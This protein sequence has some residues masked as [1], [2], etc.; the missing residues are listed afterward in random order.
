MKY[1]VMV[2]SLMSMIFVVDTVKA[3]EMMRVRLVNHLGDTEQLNVSF[4]GE[5]F[6]LDPTVHL[7]EGVTYTLTKKNEKLIVEGG[8]ETYVT[9]EPFL[10]IPSTYDYQHSVSINERPYLGAMEIRIEDNKFIR[11]VNQLP[12][13]D[14]LKGVVPFEVF[15][16]WSLETLKAQSLAARTY[17]AMHSGKEIDDTISY[18]VYGGYMWDKNTTKAV[19]ETEGEVITYKDKLISAFYSAS[20]GGMTENNS[21]VWGGEALPF[22]PIKEDPYDPTHPW[23]FSIH[24]TQIDLDDI[25]GTDPKWWDDLEEKDSEITTNIKSWLNRN[26]YPGDIKILSIPSF[27]ISGE[28]LAS[29]RSVIG[30]ISVDF[31]WQLFDGMVLYQQVNLQDVQLNRIRPIIGGNIFKSYL[32]ESLEKDNNVYTMEGKGYGHGVGMSQWGASVMG[33]NGKSYKEIIEFYF[34][35][36]SISNLESDF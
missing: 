25:N 23:E 33:E 4:E 15:P 8:E 16:E 34:P 31:L 26:G 11:P 36:T 10:L 24:E 22:F 17:A 28:Q 1:I 3:E 18:Q 32:I 14:Y 27:E 20:N 2:L 6:T 12:L 21:H 35:K 5:Y 7:E 29:D 30:S 19:N 13:E 9:S